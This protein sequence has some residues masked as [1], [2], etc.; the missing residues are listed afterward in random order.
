MP[1]LKRLPGIDRDVE[2]RLLIGM[3]VSDKVL[4]RVYPFIKPELM[5]LEVSKEVSKWITDFYRNYQKAPRNHIQDL[6]QISK[7][8]LRPNLSE[9]IQLFLSQLS[10]E[11]LSEK[12][13]A[14]INEDFIIDRGLQYLRGRH[15]RSMIS[16]V[17]S[18]LDLDKIEEA[19]KIYDEK[20]KLIAK[21][22]YRWASPLDDLHY[23]NSVFD[24]KE[25][26][27]LEMKG[28]LGSMI[29]PLYK[30]YLLGVMGPMKRGKTW[31]LQDVTFDSLMSRRRTVL[32][33]L[34]M[35]DTQMAERIY[36]Q[37]G[38]AGDLDMDYKIPCF[39]CIANQDNKCSKPKRTNHSSAPE[40]YKPGLSYKPCT[41]CRGVPKEEENFIPSSWFVT[42]NRPKISRTVA[43][44]ELRKFQKMYGNNLLRAISFPAG[45]ITLRELE[46]QID[47]LEIIEGFIPDVIV[48]DYADLLLPDIKYK[49][50][51]H[52][53]G[54]IW[55]GLKGM[56]SRRSCLVVTASQSNRESTR[57]DTLSERD[58][59][60]DISKLAHVN[61][62]I[63]LNQTPEEKEQMVWRIGILENRHR[64]FHRRIQ[65]MALQQFELG[66][67][68][69]DSEI[70]RYEYKSE[71]I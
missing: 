7:S 67:S 25:V 3:I 32:I 5:E 18:L 48:I 41:A 20:G 62:M 45:G 64:Q 12:D 29:G 56:A 37:M 4:N 28:P 21:A 24:E 14:G 53:I 46:D 35:E 71:K 58:T 55:K 49:E 66:Q 54:D 43:R 38:M 39:D 6:F 59:A 63:T 22:Q 61:V 36:R 2:K 34:E 15:L 57:K 60:E 26:P 9:E 69:L 8:K 19:E 17:S 65:L 52:Q 50:Y 68:I 44:R 42:Y 23:L 31:A 40:K 51:R 30:G 13:P 33:S 27:I 47:Q 16:E 70:I 1:L 11:Y 10:E